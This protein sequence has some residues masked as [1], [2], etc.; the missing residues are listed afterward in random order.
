MLTQDK[1]KEGEQVDYCLKCKKGFNT[2]LLK[3]WLSSKAQKKCIH[4][5]E[6]YNVTTFKRGKV[7]ILNDELQQLLN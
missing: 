3:Q 7:R 5:T 2:E 1:F 4:C 6:P